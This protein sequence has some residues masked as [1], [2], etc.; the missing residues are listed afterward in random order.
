MSRDIVTSRRTVLTT[1][2]GLAAVGLAGTASVGATEHPS[3]PNGTPGCPRG[4]NSGPLECQFGTVDR[5]V[6]GQHVVVLLEDGRD[7]IGQEVIP[8]EEATWV[9]EGDHVIVRWKDGEFHNIT[10]APT[11]A[12]GR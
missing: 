7:T 10:P 9:D 2:T 6:D 12:S 11:P 1:L 5:I 3:S 4:G 8:R